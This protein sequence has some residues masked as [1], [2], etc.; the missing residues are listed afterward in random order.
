LTS[1]DTAK[2]VIELARE[3]KGKQIV[4]MDV[5]DISSF[6]DFFVVVSGESTIQ[7]KAICD[8]I[9]DELRKESVYPYSKEGYENLNWVLM[10]YVDVVV[11]VFNNDTREFYGLERLWADAKMEFIT[12]EVA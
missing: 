11:H 5:T 10:D 7:I 3:K 6:T 12:E 9:E 8:H 1:L 4:L 2:R